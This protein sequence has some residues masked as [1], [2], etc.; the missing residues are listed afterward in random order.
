MKVVGSAELDMTVQRTFRPL[1]NKAICW[2][3]QKCLEG[4]LYEFDVI[5]NYTPILMSPQFIDN[6]PARSRRS[7]K[8]RT[9]FCSPQL[10]YARYVEGDEREKRRVF[11]DGLYDALG[12]MEKF[13][14]NDEQL[15]EFRNL[16]SKAGDD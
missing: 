2:L 1:R 13:G 14:A 5:L 8:D 9:V 7:I 15:E 11:Y 10:D 6:Y 12:Y 16:I 3:A 4:K